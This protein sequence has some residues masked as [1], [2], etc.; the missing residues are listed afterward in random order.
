VEVAQHFPAVPIGLVSHGDPLRALY[1]RLLN[2]QGPFPPYPELVK[3]LSLDVAQA[4]RV[5][6]SPT[7][8]VASELVEQGLS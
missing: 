5:A 6:I 8:E 2:P 4:V 1:F 7:G 3:R